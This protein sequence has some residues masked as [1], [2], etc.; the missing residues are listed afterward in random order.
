MK[1]MNVKM[2]KFNKH[3]KP[4]RK[5]SIKELCTTW[6]DKPCDRWMSDEDMIENLCELIQ[7]E[8]IDLDDMKWL[9]FYPDY[10]KVRKAYN[11]MNKINE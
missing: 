1:G 8:I 7:M 4:V 6:I 10:C 11:N 5:C 2:K 3:N 9:L